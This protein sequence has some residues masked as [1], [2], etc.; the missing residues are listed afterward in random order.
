MT[1]VIRAGDL[2]AHD[3]P[4][5][6]FWRNEQLSIRPG[7]ARLLFLLLRDGRV[8]TATILDIA[9]RTS[10]QSNLAAVQVSQLRHAIKTA[11]VPI[12]IS[13]VKDDG[14]RLEWIGAEP[15]RQESWKAKR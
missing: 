13:R 11:G 15:R 2:V 7:S 8:S 14:Y 9:P 5:S 4:A 6:A 1:S 12:K 10:G 3:H